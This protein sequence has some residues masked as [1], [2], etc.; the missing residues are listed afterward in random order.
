[1]SKYKYA[2]DLRKAQYEM[3]LNWCDSMLEFYKDRDHI[4]KDLTHQ[5]HDVLDKV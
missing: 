2:K 5:T 4:A 3:E 1:M